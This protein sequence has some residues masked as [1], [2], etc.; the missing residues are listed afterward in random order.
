MVLPVTSLRL[1]IIIL[2]WTSLCMLF[3]IMLSH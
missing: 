3:H 2:T 1:D